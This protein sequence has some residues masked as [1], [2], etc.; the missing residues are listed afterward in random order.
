MP[1]STQVITQCDV[2]G[3]V[4]CLTTVSYALALL[5]GMKN[6]IVMTLDDFCT[7]YSCIHRRMECWTLYASRG[8]MCAHQIASKAV[9][10]ILEALEFQNISVCHKFSSG[11]QSH[12]KPNES[13]TGSRYWLMCL[14]L[15][16]APNLRMHGAK[17]PSLY[18]FIVSCLIKHRDKF[19]FTLMATFNTSDVNWQVQCETIRSCSILQLTMRHVAEW[20]MSE[21]RYMDSYCNRRRSMVKIKFYLLLI[22]MSWRHIGEWRYSS[23]HS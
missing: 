10:T 8:P 9:Q 19:A 16:L 22:I 13:C 11:T 3:T 14:H 15:H 23:T 20:E 4:T 7:I 18:V 21:W 6:R 2:F 17:P 1:V 5:K 12:H